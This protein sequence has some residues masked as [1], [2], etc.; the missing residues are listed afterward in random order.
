MNAVLLPLIW[1]LPL[2]LAGL[3][4]RPAARWLLPIA[5]L[6][7]LMAALTLPVGSSVSLPWVL[8]GMEL[9]LDATGRIFLLFSALLWLLAALYAAGIPIGNGDA[10]RQRVCFLLAMAGNLGLILAQDMVSFYVGFALMGLAAYGLIVAP[11]SQRARRAANR[12][13]VWTLIGELVLFVAVILL[14]AQQDGDLRFAALA[15]NPPAGLVAG[16]LV[17]GFG[18]KT[19]LP[20]L[21]FWLPPAY[22]VTP[23][24]AVAVLS[25]AMIK[26]GLL[27]WIRFLPPGEDTLAG[28]GQVLIFLGITGVFFGALLGLGQRQARRLLGYS[29]I[30]KMGVLSAGMGAML[31]W[32]QAAPMLTGA[33]A[34]YA[35]HHAWV[36]GALFL[37][38]GLAERSGL[39][40]WILAGLGFLALALAGAPLTSGA[41]AKA[42]LKDGLPTE[43]QGL[44]PVLAA[45]AFATTLLMIRFL[46]LV[47]RRHPVRFEPC[48]APSVVAWLGLLIPIAA[49]PFVMGTAEGLW[50]NLW[51]VLSGSLLG[52]A[53]LGAAPWLRRRGIETAAPLSAW[54]RAPAQAARAVGRLGLAARFALY[55]RR[56]RLSVPSLASGSPRPSAQASAGSWS[57]AGGLWLCVGAL[58]LAALILTV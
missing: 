51:P 38:V 42:L 56:P 37:G 54:V 40:P 20:G 4:A 14:A 44:L 29:S 46:V 43:A 2:V 30:S 34:L 1:L 47:V 16:L 15:D 18:I 22:G 35:A 21:H 45:S 50:T 5:A 58:L 28:W 19:A 41:V 8:L 53:A 10:P 26:A 24:A 31:V 32:P 57:L 33:L 48:P 7:A 36:K 27:G 12:Y 9:G 55:R 13:L 39:R 23:A 6:P 49:Y 11:A 25:G 3:A 52:V 17:I